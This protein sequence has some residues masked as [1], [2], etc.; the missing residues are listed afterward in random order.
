MTLEVVKK[1]MRDEGQS[2]T[3]DEN[4]TTD[5]PPSEPKEKKATTATAP[6]DIEDLKTAGER[7]LATNPIARIFSSIPHLFLRDI[8]V[9]LVVKDETH[10]EIIKEEHEDKKKTVSNDDDDI[11]SAE[12]VVDV[13]IG[14]LS[15][16]DGEDFL[17]PF[18]NDDNLSHDGESLPPLLRT[19]TSQSLP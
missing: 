11:G 8:L 9:R 19:Q 6:I 2:P 1:P 7:V 16:T 14:L 17:S 13:G 12:V 4:S 18:N 5:V 15:C 10:E 3:D